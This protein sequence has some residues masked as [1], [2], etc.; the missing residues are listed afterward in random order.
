MDLRYRSWRL[1][2]KY[3]LNL[4]WVDCNTLRGD[5]MSKKRNFFQTESTLDEF[6][7]EL[8]VP[9]S[10]QNNVEMSCMLFFTLGIDQDVINEDHDKLVQLRHEYGVHQVHEMCRS[11]G[12]PKRHNQILVQLIPSGEGS[13]RDVIR[14]DLDLM[15]TRTKI[16]LR[17]DFCTGKL[18]K[19]NVDAEQWV[20]ILDRDSI[21]RS[22]VNT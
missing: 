14:T 12:E 8:M 17:K 20:L 15:I 5:D 19:K 3:F 13:L 7:I 4:A 2:I 18:I 6:G 11:I 21:Q 16:D 9:K 10:L 22:V 1:P